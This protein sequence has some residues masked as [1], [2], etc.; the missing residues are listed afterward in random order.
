MKWN[1]EFYTDANGVKPVKVWLMGLDEHARAV[2]MRN[3]ALLEELGIGIREPYVKAL[4][5]KLYE[6][7]A[8]DH[9]GI[10]RVIY[11]AHTGKRFILLHGFVKKTQKT[12]RK[13]IE[14]A[15]KRM[16]ELQ[17]E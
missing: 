11:F 10:Y 3:I 8:K 13:E 5:G 7:R 1:V 4:G 12:Q 15:K 9:K 17:D 2:V 14:L 6:V 16:Q